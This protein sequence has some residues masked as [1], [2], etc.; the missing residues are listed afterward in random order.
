MCGLLAGEKKRYGFFFY[1]YTPR[2]EKNV[3]W[4]KN[5]GIVRNSRSEKVQREVSCHL[6]SLL[7]I[8][9]PSD[10]KQIRIS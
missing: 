1:A 4:N 9:C 2:L 8:I 3:M 5:E 10:T 6:I 7:Y